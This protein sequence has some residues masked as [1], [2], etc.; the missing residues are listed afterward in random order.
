MDVRVARRFAWVMDELQRTGRVEIP[1]YPIGLYFKRM[2]PDLRGAIDVKPGKMFEVV[3][4][5]HPF[6]KLRSTSK[7]EIFKVSDKDYSNLF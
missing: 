3:K 1:P 5:S 7:H 6:K 2:E 4:G